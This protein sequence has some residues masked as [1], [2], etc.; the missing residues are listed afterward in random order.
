MKKTILSLMMLSCFFVA[1]AQ[2]SEI[3]AAKQNYALYEVGLQTKSPMKK[4]LEL[5]N[6]AKESTDKAI[7]NDKTKDNPEL[8]AYRSIIYSSIAVTD[9]VNKENA[10]AAFKTAQEAIAKAKE[11]DTKKENTKYI[12]SSEQNL[13]IMMQNKGVAAFNKKDY[14]EAYKSFKFIADVKPQDSLFNMYTAIAANSAQMYDEAAKYYQKTIEVN[15][16]NPALYH[17]LATIYLTKTDT[18]NAL[19][20]IE[21][22][23]AKHPEFM[24]LIYDELNI[25]INRG[26]AA[27]QI[28]KIENAIS[29]D[30]KNKTL[31]FVAGIAYSANKDLAKAEE[32]Y[33]KALEIDPSY[34]DAIYNL[35]V[36]YI[37]KGNDFINQANK[38]PNNKASEAKYNSLK[39]SFETELANA[40]PLLEKARELN[41]KDVNVLTTLREVYIK[42]NKLD[43]AAEVKKA[44]DQM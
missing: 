7:T 9:T 36:I 18:A 38:L 10:E 8:W 27:Q 4:Q 26:Q 21:E 15:P 43:K 42:L 3:N 40:L 23:R 41:P 30:P 19:K 2:K 39:K 37:N 25:Y 20:V 44:L 13:A 22:G 14:K 11:L 17:E 5:L 34:T 28:S 31:Y 1:F 29:K 12:E 24:T 35:A 33:K 16:K 6:L 32:S